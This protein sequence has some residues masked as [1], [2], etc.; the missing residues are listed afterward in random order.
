MAYTKTWSSTWEVTEEKADILRIA[1]SYMHTDLNK[2][3]EKTLALLVNFTINLG[4]RYRQRKGQSVLQILLLKK[5]QTV[6]QNPT[7]NRNI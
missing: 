1:L 4:N 3:H 2:H 5:A 7:P 6:T